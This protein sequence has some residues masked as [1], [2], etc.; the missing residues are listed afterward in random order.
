MAINSL[1]ETTDVLAPMSMKTLRRELSIWG[2]YWRT[3]E[4]GRGFARRSACDRLGET[5]LSLNGAN[6]HEMA[7]PKH[8][9]IYDGLID[10]LSL[11]CRR[12]LRAQY[13]CKKDWAL[14]GFESRKS[15]IY[16]LRRAEGALL[17]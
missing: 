13:I 9:A 12:A 1:M 16:W 15:Y 3:Q 2:R 11:E 17:D 6:V 8:V 7:T 5:H 10:R 14:L 4:Y